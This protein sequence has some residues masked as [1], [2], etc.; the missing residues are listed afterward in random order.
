MSATAWPLFLGAAVVG[1]ITRY[2]LGRRFAL[3]ILAVNIVG[4]FVLGIVFQLARVG[5]LGVD[6]YLVIG[7]GFCGSLT[8]FSTVSV[9]VASRPRLRWGYGLVT[10][11]ACLVAARLGIALGHA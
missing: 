4:S 7:S 2:E 6:P 11:V 9:D 10:L 5:D 3:G 1:A 8:T